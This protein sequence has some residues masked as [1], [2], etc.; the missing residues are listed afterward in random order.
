MEDTPT[1]NNHPHDKEAFTPTINKTFLESNFKLPPHKTAKF[2]TQLHTTALQSLSTIIT[3]KQQLEAKNRPPQQPP[4]HMKKC[5]LRTLTEDL[6]NHNYETL[7]PN[8]NHTLK[9]TQHTTKQPKRIGAQHAHVAPKKR[10]LYSPI[11]PILEKG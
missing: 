5:H 2:Q 9:D 10:G 8:H 4:P 11:E 6:D 7:Q 1:Y 3:N